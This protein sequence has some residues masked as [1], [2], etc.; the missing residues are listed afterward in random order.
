MNFAGTKAVLFETF[1]AHDYSKLLTL[2]PRVLVTVNVENLSNRSLISI[3]FPGYKATEAK[4][5]FRVNFTK[6]GVQHVL[7]HTNII[8]DIY[9]KVSFGALNPQSLITSLFLAVVE[10]NLTYSQLANNL[11]YNRVDPTLEL[12]DLARLAH[13]GKKYNSLTNSFDLTWEEFFANIKWITMQ[14]DFNYP[15]P[16]YQGRKMPFKR[17]LEAI[18]AYT[19]PNLIS[20]ETVIDR[21]LA[22]SRIP[23]LAGIDYGIIESI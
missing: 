20:L 13:R 1:D 3:T 15:M 14:E 8:V 7:S 17:Y 5:D 23:N 19:H 16:R 9:N 12:R 11:E 21:A 10:N 18:Y 6:D 22:H 4:K 2:D